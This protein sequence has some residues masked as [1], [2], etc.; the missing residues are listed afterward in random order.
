VDGVKMT[1]KNASGVFVGDR[2]D[3][4]SAREA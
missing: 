1:V 4:Y 2:L 3:L